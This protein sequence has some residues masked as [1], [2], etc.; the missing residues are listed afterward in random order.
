MK[1][2]HVRL[3]IPRQFWEVAIHERSSGYSHCSQDGALATVI[4]GHLRLAALDGVTPSPKTVRIGDVDG[5][6]WA[7]GVC[8]T[9]LAGSAA[10]LM[11]SVEAANSV[12]HDSAIVESRDQRQVAVAVADVSSTSECG[13]AE[14]TLVR[15]A[16][17]V[18][19]VKIGQVWSR[20]FDEDALTEE[21]RSALTQWIAARPGVSVLD[22]MEAE[23]TYLG[24]PEAWKS[25]AL[26]RFFDIKVE[27]AHFPCVSE[28]LLAT[29]GAEIALS[30]DRKSVT[31]NLTDKVADSTIIHTM[32][33]K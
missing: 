1:S 4:N 20:V 33:T 17:A 27:T 16:D 5:A 18:A 14:I 26:G 10:P 29:D 23:E 6:V 24:S 25:A 28:L 31:A 11:E 13:G 3:E 30:P 9:M 19:W 21:A 22:Q 2:S 32:F 12:L 15:A 7:T 8:S